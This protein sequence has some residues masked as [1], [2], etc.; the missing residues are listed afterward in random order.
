[1]WHSLTLP[2]A[3][4]F[5]LVSV[6][7]QSTV[8]PSSNFVDGLKHTVKDL[9]MSSK[10]VYYDISGKPYLTCGRCSA[11]VSVDKSKVQART[12]SPK[13]PAADSAGV[14]SAPSPSGPEGGAPAPGGAGIQQEGTYSG[15]AVVCPNVRTQNNTARRLPLAARFFSPLSF[16]S[17]ACFSLSHHSARIRS[18]SKLRRA[19]T[20]R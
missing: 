11:H 4:S 7:R 18:A 12:P 20:P 19:A 17:S 3:F 5:L 8:I 15:E 2:L 9:S 16:S 10:K 13:A 6:C 14:G 1:M